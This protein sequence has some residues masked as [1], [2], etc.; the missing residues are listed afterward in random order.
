[1]QLRE[2]IIK[3]L[4]AF[5]M[6]LAGS[7]YLLAE[8]SDFSCGSLSNAYGPYDYRTDK[9]KLGIV[10]GGHLTPEV[11][12]LS[13]GKTGAIG[14]D[15]DYTLRAF[16]NHHPAL[17]AMVRLGEKQRL[18]KP[19]GAKYSVECYLQR[20]N[21]FRSDDAMVKMIYANFLAKNKR[22]A[23]AI[24]LLDEVVE[25]GEENS[26]LYY[27]MGLIY[28]DLNKHDKAL[29]Y[30]HL[31]YRMGFPLP[32]LRDRLKRLR[33]WSEVPDESGVKE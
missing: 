12:N 29:Y 16:P 15:I 4:F 13:R 10:E 2:K 11:L 31:A 1:M 22:G 23:E 6:G 9:D 33:K 26:N 7:Q 25:L 14:A 32:G 3:S 18:I 20:A 21:R 27:N 28:L 5:A 30:A 24:K 8:V 19:I 17:M